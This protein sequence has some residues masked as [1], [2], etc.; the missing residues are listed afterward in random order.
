MTEEMG[1]Q[2]V[3]EGWDL[4]GRQVCGDGKENRVHAR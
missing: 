3:T 1:E 4:L 2:S